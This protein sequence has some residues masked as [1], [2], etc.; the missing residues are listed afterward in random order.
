[1][2]ATYDPEFQ[3]EALLLKAIDLDPNFAIAHALI[4]DMYTVRYLYTG[5]KEHLETAR[6]AARKSMD[7]DPAEPWANFALGL[8][9]TYMRPLPEAGHYLKQ[10][11]TLNPNDG[12]FL[13]FY[14]M[15]LNFSGRTDEALRKIEEVLVRDPYGHEWF[16]D[17]QATIL[18][19]AKRHQ[20]AIE[21][22]SRMKSL[23]PWS[24]C[25][26]AISH[27]ELGRTAEAQDCL[28]SFRTLG[29]GTTPAGF[30]EERQPYADATTRSWL[31]GVLR[32]LETAAQS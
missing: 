18:A 25:Y 20:E 31:T 10:S 16:W 14:A 13:A 27:A 22:F 6:R 24:C 4:S 17:M 28:A 5:N 32:R 30:I 26:L 12:F 3:A 29:P 1:M 2:F 11:I 7:L 19:V 15:W 21:S 8:A 9:L 23:P